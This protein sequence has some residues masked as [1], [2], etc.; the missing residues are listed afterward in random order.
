MG[1]VGIATEK[2]LSSFSV[3]L[4]LTIILLAVARRISTSVLLF[5]L[6]SAIITAEVLATGF[7][8]KLA[9]A[10]LVGILIFVIKVVAIPRAF[11]VLTKRLKTV[12]DVKA[13]TTPSQSVFVVAV[14]IY[15]SYAAVHS[16]GGAVRAPGDSLAAAIALILTG[17]FLMVSRKKAVMQVL[18]LLVMENGIF[19]AALLTTFGMPL[20]IEIGIFF[21]ILM[22]LLLMGIFMFRISDTFEHLDVSKLRRLRG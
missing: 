22:G 19:L 7:Q 16:Y 20:V 11:F 3:F 4:F 1:L 10:Y 15:L 13:S 5:S 12:H 9:S 6:Q 14:M 17:A 18:G 8:E 2:I 21:D